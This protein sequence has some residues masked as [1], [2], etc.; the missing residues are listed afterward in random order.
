MNSSAGVSPLSCGHLFHTV[1]GFFHAALNQR[2]R[3]RLETRNSKL[4][5]ALLRLRHRFMGLFRLAAF[6]STHIHRGY[7]V[8]ILFSRS[9]VRIAEDGG[10]DEVCVNA[11]ILAS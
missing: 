2:R 4:E 8:E 1:A 9:H 6:V 7:R 3:S 5:T 10:L 11:R